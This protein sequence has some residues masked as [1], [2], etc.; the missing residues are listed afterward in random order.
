MYLSRQTLTQMAT[1]SASGVWGDTCL[2]SLTVGQPELLHRHLVSP[3]NERRPALMISHS[4]NRRRSA[5]TLPL[6]PSAIAM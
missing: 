1:L 3:T 2:E 6:D 4:G 5:R